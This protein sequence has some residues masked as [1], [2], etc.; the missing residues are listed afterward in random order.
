MSALGILAIWREA[1]ALSTIDV[2]RAGTVAALRRVRAAEAS[3]AALA[4]ALEEHARRT[5]AIL[6]SALDAFIGL[7]DDGRIT[8][9]NPAATR[10]YGWSAAEAVGTRLDELLSVFRADG[11]KLDARVDGAFLEHAIVRGP[12][13]Y[14]VVRKDARS[15]RS[16]RASGPRTSR[17]VGPTPRPCA[18]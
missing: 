8:S 6:D 16:N 2:E 11:T 4:T 14:S 12:V 5:E 9:W 18:T 1:R 3:R 15:P 10:L 13:V 7:D 17:E